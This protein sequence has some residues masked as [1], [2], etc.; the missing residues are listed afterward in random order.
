MP[1][2]RFKIFVSSVQK[3]F[4]QFRLDLK[5][6]LLGLN[7]RQRQVIKHA[8][9]AGRIDNAQYRDITGV[10]GSTALRELRQLAELGILDKIGDT[11]RAAHYVIAKYKPVINPPNTLRRRTQSRLNHPNLLAVIWSESNPAFPRGERCKKDHE[12]LRKKRPRQCSC[13]R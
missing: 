1:A 11:G 12:S 10:S 5:D 4:Q 3:E 13:V 2:T 8:K 9:V 7:D 6:F